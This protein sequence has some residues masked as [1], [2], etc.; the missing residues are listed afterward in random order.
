MNED[1]SDREKAIAQ[2]AMIQSGT[3]N[4]LNTPSLQ[5]LPE[6]EALLWLNAA[7]FFIDIV[8]YYDRYCAMSYVPRK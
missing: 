3:V 7:R 6:D 2:L 4:L 8:E 1:Y 5:D